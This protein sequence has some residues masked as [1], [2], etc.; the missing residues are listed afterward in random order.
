MTQTNNQPNETET[1]GQVYQELGEVRNKTTISTLNALNFNLITEK[2][3]RRHCLG[4]HKSIGYLGPK[5]NTH[6]IIC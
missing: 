6:R 4:T 3:W 2:C 5:R 1:F